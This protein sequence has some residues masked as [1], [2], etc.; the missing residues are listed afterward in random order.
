[1][2]E[3]KRFLFDLECDNFLEHVKVVHCIVIQDVDTNEVYKFR[4]NEIKKGLKKLQEAD[5]LIGHNLLGYDLGVINKLYPRWTHS[6]YIYDTLIAAKICYPDIKQRDF[7]KLRSVM[8]KDPKDRTEI[9]T[10]R[11]RSIGKHS[12]K[13]YGLR[14]GLTKGTFGE[15]TGFETY[16]EDMLEYCVRDVEV[17]AKLFHRLESENISQDALD[18]EFKS[19]QI[20][21]E[22]TEK[23]F[24]FDLDKAH[25]LENDLLK[26]KQE[27]SDLIT[28]ELGG[29]FMLN[30]G[31]KVPKRTTKYK[32]LLRGT[33]TKGAA[34]SKIKMKPFNANS[35]SDL[36]TRLIERLGWKPKVFGKDNK[37]TLSEDILDTLEYPVTKHISEYMTIEKRLGMLVSG[38]A[39]WLK[40]YDEESKS[41]HG[42]VNTLGCA[43][44]RA[45]H[46]RP[47]L[48]Q[49]PATY[50]PWGTECRTLFKAPDGMKLFG[51]DA[52]GLELRMLAH[53]MYSFDGGEYANIVLND[54]IH[55]FNQKAAKL[56]TRD[57]AKKYI[58]SKIYGSGI[59]N[60]AETCGMS[61]KAMKEIV[62]NFDENLPALA[63]LT[64][65][66]KGVIRTRGFVKAL[67]GRK[68][69]CSSEHA[70]LN[71]LLQSAG[72]IV[73]KNWMNRVH[74]LL[75][76]RDSN[77]RDYV[78]QLAFV[79]DELQIAYDEN[80]ITHEELD[81]ISKD[82]MTFTQE[83]LGI[84]IK[85]DSD[86]KSGD[87]WAD[88]H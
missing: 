47:N 55:T 21:L 58:Y 65:T 45:A 57:L 83:K 71:Y 28:K 7:N 79:H 44:S 75:E 26:R 18:T 85:L 67:D 22:Q 81:K 62:V 36:S 64:S 50:S 15:E 59:K 73:C 60:L 35:R 31:I 76:S 42:R 16:S 12:L 70:A 68:I 4:P 14:L 43:T 51:T 2:A 77:Y 84:K 86:S 80:K 27:L 78:K 5:V 33:Y 54:D 87:N 53:Y 82:A 40:L 20:C 69:Y 66:V 63:S 88:T 17:N 24:N 48:G 13:A 52:S 11:M 9:E 74:E 30:L 23:G 41:I 32:E 56:P 3:R 34:Y 10:L 19:Q 25:V 72:A 46:M 8:N 49:V 6:A 37:P 1:M 29:D 39:A 61:M 38:N